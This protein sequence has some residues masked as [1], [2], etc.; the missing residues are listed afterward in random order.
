M[1]S[2]NVKGSLTYKEDKPLRQAHQM[3]KNDLNIDG[4]GLGMFWGNQIT[5]SLGSL[6]KRPPRGDGINLERVWKETTSLRSMCLSV[7][8]QQEG[9]T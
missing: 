6:T 4:D 5:K 7:W 2:K 8:V 1:P 9:I 3:I